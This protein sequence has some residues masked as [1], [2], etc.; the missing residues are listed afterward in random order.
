MRHVS[1]CAIARTLGFASLLGSASLPVFAAEA[2]DPLAKAIAVITG[3][4]TP[5]TAPA[6]KAAAAPVAAPTAPTP[7][8]QPTV[9]APVVAPV[10]KVAPQQQPPAPEPATEPVSEP[11]PPRLMPMGQRLEDKLQAAHNRLTLTTAQAAL[12]SDV[13]KVLQDNQKTAAAVF[14]DKPG[15]AVDAVR[16]GIKAAETRIANLKRLGSVLEKFYGSLTE[17]QR[18]ALDEAVLPQ[19]P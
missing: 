18:R 16:Q 3:K 7:V 19:R 11:E 1:L 15:N 8:V 9:T 4:E 13:S 12:W 14:K 17:V 6:A 10:A 2:T 5:T